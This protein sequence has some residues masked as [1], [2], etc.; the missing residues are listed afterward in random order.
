MLICH[1]AIVLRATVS[2]FMPCCLVQVFACQLFL[3]YIV[4]LNEQIIKDRDGENMP[5]M[6]KTTTLV[7]LP[8]TTFGHATKWAYSTTLVS[9][10][11]VT[12]ERGGQK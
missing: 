1:A 6:I 5:Y 9:P 11:G 4:S 8:L 3:A 12:Q 2:A 10:H 7:Q